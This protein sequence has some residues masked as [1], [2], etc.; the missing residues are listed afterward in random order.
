MLSQNSKLKTQRSYSQLRLPFCSALLPQL[1]QGFLLMLKLAVLSW[2]CASYKGQWKE[3]TTNI[4]LQTRCSTTC[5]HAELSLLTVKGIKESAGKEPQYR[6]VLRW[7][8]QNKLPLA[9]F[10]LVQSLAEVKQQDSDSAH[11]FLDTDQETFMR[12][13]KS[14]L[15]SLFSITNST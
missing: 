6:E 5:A 9:Q 4:T 10:T 15:G 2:K 1:T 8:N 7:I 12:F 14:R 13:S 11:R 3:T